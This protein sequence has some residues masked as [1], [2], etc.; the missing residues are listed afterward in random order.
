[1][2]L[3]VAL[4]LCG[5]GGLARAAGTAPSLDAYRGHVTYVDFWA[6]WC[7]PCAE[8]F[9]WLNAMQAKY[10]ARGLHVVGVGVDTQSASADRFLRAHAPQF[11][12]V[13]DPDGALAEQ[14]AIEGMPYAVLLDADGHVLSRHSGF[15]AG[16]TDEYE[17]AIQ[18]A[19][20]PRGTTP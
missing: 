20:S 5:C 14:Y 9:P 17:H 11:P 10:G 3:F 2:R 12:I 16:Q 8:S 7:G 13:R 4:L 19:L 15:R 6:S 18:D 1:M